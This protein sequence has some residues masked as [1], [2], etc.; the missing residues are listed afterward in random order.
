MKLDLSA[1]NYWNCSDCNATCISR[2]YYSYC[3]DP[4]TGCCEC[5]PYGYSCYYCN[6]TCANSTNKVKKVDSL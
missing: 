2:G 4:A 5:L 6:N 1:V 3:A